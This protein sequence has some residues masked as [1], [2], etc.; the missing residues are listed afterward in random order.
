M[1]WLIARPPGYWMTRVAGVLFFF[2]PKTAERVFG[3]IVAHYRH[4]MIEAEASGKSPSKMFLRFRHWGGF[5]LAL[6]AELSSG[7]LGKIIRA[8][9]GS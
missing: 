1:I 2:S 7:F 9:K 6:I 3:E 5:V 8:F 4:E